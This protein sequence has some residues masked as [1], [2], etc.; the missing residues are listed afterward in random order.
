MSN[1]SL[2]WDES[3]DETKSIVGTIVEYFRAP[4]GAKNIELCFILDEME[5]AVVYSQKYLNIK[6]DTYKNVWRRLHTAPDADQWPTDIPA[7][8]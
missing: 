3:L 5:D 8:I 7:T 6:S 2:S 1:F 4:L